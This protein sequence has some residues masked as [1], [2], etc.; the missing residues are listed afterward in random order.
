MDDRETK[1][2][3]AIA[4]FYQTYFRNI[5]FKALPKELRK[6]VGDVAYG[7]IVRIVSEASIVAVPTMAKTMG[8]KISGEDPLKAL[9]ELNNKCHVELYEETSK[10]GTIGEIG[11][12][13]TKYE[14]NKAYFFIEDQCPENVVDFAPYVGIVYGIAKALGINDITPIKDESMKK[15]VRSKYVVYPKKEGN[16]CMV[17]VERVK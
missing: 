6:L 7:I 4:F 9:V 5:T 12:I 16:K 14:D 3:E 13:P 1:I 17:V 2:L 8:Y 11:L 10:L 15:L